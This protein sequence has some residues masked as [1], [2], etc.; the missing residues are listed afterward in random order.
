M[1]S[2][3]FISLSLSILLLSGCEKGPASYDDCILINIQNMKN[4]NYLPAITAACKG[5]FPMDF[6]WGELSRKTG[7]KTWTEVK[8]GAEDR[9][10]SKE[11]QRQAK[12]QYWAE[13]LK[14]QVR[15][16]FWNEAHGKFMSEK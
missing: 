9:Q 12:E 4:N 2:N 7:F 1:Q 8:M 6:N 10:L 11:E 14:P 16:D 5:K 13:V 15:S 3:S